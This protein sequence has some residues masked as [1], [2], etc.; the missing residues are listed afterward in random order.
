MIEAE[1]CQ[2]IK[3]I[4]NIAVEVPCVVDIIHQLENF[5]AFE[6]VEVFEQ[7]VDE[8]NLHGRVFV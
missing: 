1:I 2:V 3:M 4:L 8:V 7:L 5:P 6:E